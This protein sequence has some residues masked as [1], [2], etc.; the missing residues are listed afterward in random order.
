MAEVQQSGGDSGKKGHQKKMQIRVDFTPMVDMNMLLITFL[1]LCTE[2]FIS[3]AY[4][5][6]L[7]DVPRVKTYINCYTCNRAAVEAVMDKLLGKSKF[8]GLSPVDAFC[9]LCDTRI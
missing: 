8:T 3:F 6:H 9:G 7:Q 1:M 5:Y 4:P 2:I